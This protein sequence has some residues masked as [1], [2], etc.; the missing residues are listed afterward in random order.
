MT[1]Y[2]GTSTAQGSAT[3]QA[4]GGYLAGPMR[5][6][7]TLNA[8][9]TIQGYLAGPMRVAETIRASGVVK[10]Q[11]TY[12]L[13]AVDSTIAAS[14]AF[15]PSEIMTNR[16]TSA[17]SGDVNVRSTLHKPGETNSIGLVLLGSAE[18][19]SARSIATSGTN[20][21]YGYWRGSNNMTTVAKFDQMY[22]PL[23]GSGVDAAGKPIVSLVTDQDQQPG[24]V[25]HPICTASSVSWTY[26]SGMGGWSGPGGAC[27]DLG[28]T[29][30][31]EPAG[32]GYDGEVRY[33]PC[34]GSPYSY[35]G[36]SDSGLP[37]GLG[38]FIGSARWEK[39]GSLIP[40]LGNEAIRQR[41]L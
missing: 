20:R 39:A 37:E 3:I 5:V 34:T 22:V 17:L 21:E 8:S 2:T 19:V 6:S 25:D 18:H 11:L 31:A 24:L 35:Y 14:G 32:A 38:A 33:V 12:G 40:Q 10:A 36:G 16:G 15:Y 13:H 4:N 27:A 9:A 26:N 7:K 1:I 28:C 41:C 29:E 23:E 30:G